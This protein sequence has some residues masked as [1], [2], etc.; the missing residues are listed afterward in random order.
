[1]RQKYAE[2][3]RDCVFTLISHGTFLGDGI[4]QPLF[5]TFTAKLESTCRPNWKETLLKECLIQ[6]VKVLYMVVMCAS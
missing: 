6:L 1:M 2:I 5:S 3:G 4:V